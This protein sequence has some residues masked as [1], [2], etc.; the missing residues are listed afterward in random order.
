[1]GNSEHGLWQRHIPSGES[2]VMEVRG[3][4]D[5]AKTTLLG[6]GEGIKSDKNRTKQKRVEPVNDSRSQ[7]ERMNPRSQCTTVTQSTPESPLSAKGVSSRHEFSRALTGSG[8]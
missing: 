7:N 8:R 6:G 5:L 1:M 4:F 2:I 3:G